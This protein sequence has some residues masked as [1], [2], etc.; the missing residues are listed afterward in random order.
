MPSAAKSPNK[1]YVEHLERDRRLVVHHTSP[2]ATTS[3]VPVTAA[4]SGEHK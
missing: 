3:V 2:P 1:I 4:A